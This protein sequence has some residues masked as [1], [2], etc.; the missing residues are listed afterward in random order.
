[1]CGM[2]AILDPGATL[3]AAAAAAM[4][5]ALRHRG[6]DGDA[7]RRLG[8]ATLVHTRLAIID[9]AGGDQPLTG[10]DGSVSAVVNGEI[11]NHL[12][13]RAEL[14]A[15]GHRFATHSDSEVVVHLYEEHGP[16]GLARMN[17]IFGLALWDARRER[18]VAARDP[19][20][21]K[22]VYWWTDGRRVALASEVGALLATGLARAEVDG[23][24]LDHYLATRFVPA[25][26]TLFAGVSKLA[27][28]SM[29]VAEG[30]G[31]RIEGFREAPGPVLAG[32]SAQE[33]RERF[34]AAVGRQRMSDVPYGAFLSGGVDSAAVVAAMQRA[35]DAAPS[36]FTIGFPGA[37]DVIDE[38]AVA[39]RTAHALGT[40]HHDTA[41]VQGDF[42][43]A[44]D[45]CVQS[46][47][48]PCAIPS[49]PALQE[50][51]AFAA[52]SVKVVLS[53]Q[54]AD[55]PHGGY[56]RH[57]AAAALGV[58]G[59]VPAV[60]GRLAAAV[61][62]FERAGQL[63]RL[64]GPM[65]D[66]ERL[67]AL[68]EVTS[69]EQRAALLGGGSPAGGARGPA[70]GGPAAE[71]AAE[72][73]ALVD[74]VRADVGDRPLLD[75]ALYVDTHLF[76]PDR[77]LICADKMSMAHAL[78]HR[79]P[80]LDVELMRWVERVPGRERAGLRAGKRLHQEAVAGLVPREALERPKHGFASPYEQWMH[81]SLAAEVRRR[82]AAGR[83]L[84][85]LVEPAAVGRLVDEH[86]ARRADHK[87]L[88]YALLELAVWHG[89]FVEGAAAPAPAPAA[90]AR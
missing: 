54:G 61:P 80:F 70:G 17:G 23:V 83:P 52:Q 55:E 12:E 33:L 22:P 36:T 66:G 43:A 27:P 10:E 84:S 35:G 51:S 73:L 5:G 21:V 28:A 1:M 26:R 32:A 29:L 46:L 20:G 39:A 86:L 30:G 57:R 58:L 60:A 45:R 77:L 40:E 47:E 72:R 9:V 67:L 53:G 41:M 11:Y 3:P 74:G 76:L 6:P 19:L 82:Y 65:P 69:P 81:T 14:E 15:R 78:E 31:V 75:Q 18:L 8:P 68:A 38:R 13:L 62:R 64:L 59:R 90:A 2:G 71:A 89:A 50:L 88:L 16:A 24:A 7:V 79:V 56:G 42:L 44:L 63:S 37:G 48:E 25:P 87:R 49:A 4:C 34:V 85:E